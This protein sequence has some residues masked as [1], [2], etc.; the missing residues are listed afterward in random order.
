MRKGKIKLDIPIE[1]LD[2][3]H[4][5]KKEGETL[6]ETIERYVRIGMKIEGVLP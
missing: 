4:N 5:A 3:V 1:L 6:D 2:K